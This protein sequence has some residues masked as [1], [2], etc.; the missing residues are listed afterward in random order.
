MNHILVANQTK[1]AEHAKVELSMR[2]MLSNVSHDLK[3]PLTVVLGYVE[4]LHTEPTMGEDERQALLKKLHMKTLEVTEL[5]HKFFD[6]AKLESGDQE[7]ELTRINMNEVCQNNILSFYE[8]LFRS[9]R[10]PKRKS[11][12]P[13]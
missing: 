1:N 2:K 5:I 9:D 8:R 11:L 3:T 12:C 7:I 4:I 10:Y 6:L 13:W